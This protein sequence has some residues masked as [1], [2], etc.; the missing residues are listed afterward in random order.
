MNP[1]PIDTRMRRQQWLSMFS[2][3]VASL[4]LVWNWRNSS[5]TGPDTTIEA[6]RFVL[7]DEHGDQRG[8]WEIAPQGNAFLRIARAGQNGAFLGESLDG[9]QLTM[10]SNTGAG[11]VILD[12][13]TDT[14]SLLLQGKDGQMARF[15]VNADQLVLRNGNSEIIANAGPD[16]SLISMNNGNQPRL[17]LGS[18]LYGDREWRLRF[19]RSDGSVFFQEPPSTSLP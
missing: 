15:G 13:M 11:R 4:S 5:N 17:N 9:P 14:P 2:L 12:T 18:P 10:F 1:D 19:M 3:L 16:G 7:K 6:R 8:V